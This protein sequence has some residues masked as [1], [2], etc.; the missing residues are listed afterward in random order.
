MRYQLRRILCNK[1]KICMIMALLIVP[2]LELFQFL[3]E[4]WRYEV[5]LPYPL[6]ATF[7]S[8]YSRGHILQ[9]LYL[10]FLPLYLLVIVGEDC[11]EDYQIGY[12]NILV[13]KN[14]K[15]RYIKDKLKAGF[16][17]PF[18]ILVC[19]LSLNLILVQIICHN[20]TYLRYGGEYMVYDS[21][22]MP[23]TVLFELSYTHPL[24]TNI[25]YIFLI[26]VFSGLI[27]MVGTGLSIV[28][29]DRKIVYAIT[30]ALWFVP[31][32]FKNSFMLVFQ[33]FMEYGFH[34]IIPLAV[35]GVG[36]YV[37]VIVLSAMWEEKFVEV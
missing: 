28:L 31:I 19:G 33:P 11:I 7:L 23:E 10:W 14:G 12:K 26:A 37:L 32:L 2:S 17:I 30:F 25:I 9:S 29:H 6:Y 4:H 35:W 20:G 22:V 8:V 18:L 21:N 34:V 16:F 5:E 36:L 27:G 24:I 3:Y 1:K 13:C 15:N